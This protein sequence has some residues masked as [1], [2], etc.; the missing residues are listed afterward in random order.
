METSA[1][2]PLSPGGDTVARWINSIV[3]ADLIIDGE[4]M[5]NGN[6]QSLLARGDGTMDNSNADS[7]I[8]E[9]AQRITTQDL[10][11]PDS[12][13]LS[14][15]PHIDKNNK[16]R[17]RED[18]TGNRRE[19]APE[20]KRIKI[21]AW[22]RAQDALRTCNWNTSKARKILK[23]R[24]VV[25]QCDDEL[26]CYHLTDAKTPFFVRVLC[27]FFIPQKITIG[28]KGKANT[29]CEFPVNQLDNVISAL[30]SI[31]KGSKSKT[32]HLGK[33]GEKL[34]IEMV[35]GSINISQLFPPHIKKYVQKNNL[36]LHLAP[37]D[38]HFNLPS[39]ELD[40]LLDSMLEALQFKKM[41]QN[42]AEQRQSVFENA[43]DDMKQSHSMS[44]LDFA[45]ALLEIF[46]KL[47]FEE[48]ERYPVS[49][50]LPEYYTILKPFF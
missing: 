18:S 13:P 35:N 36:G 45:V 19:E 16:K 14:T 15:Y 49:I 48:G 10:M 33:R 21:P 22:V 4:N 7:E 25:P 30:T 50:V 8:F 42:I 38:S 34:K 12:I 6:S 1:S 41:T 5:G 37:E 9:N 26:T 28:A 23:T 29:K 2:S 27:S 40:L 31:A 47:K 46:Y 24:Y 17:Q 44:A 43:V 32:I 20:S 3:D 39:S 11:V